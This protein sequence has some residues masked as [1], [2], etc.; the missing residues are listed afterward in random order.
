MIRRLLI[1]VV[2][3][4]AAMA[5]LPGSVLAHGDHDA[6]PLAREIGA[7]PYVISLWQVYAD[8]STA[9]TPHLI[10]MFD[11][12][13]AAPPEVAVEVAVNGR[14][15]QVV[16]SSTTANGFE[17]TEGLNTGD[18]V[19]VTIAAGAGSWGLEPVVVPPPPTS[20]I[21]VDQLLYA[22]IFLTIW[23]AWWVAR[24]TAR[25][26]RRPIDRVPRNVPAS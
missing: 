9:M 4:S 11:G 24:R 15:V 16:P 2:A 22:S 8:T 5:A 20:M 21:P 23:V 12:V 14:S 6:R 19:A 3:A 25:A 26:W 7:G 18:V 13:R 1:G 10:V 17:T